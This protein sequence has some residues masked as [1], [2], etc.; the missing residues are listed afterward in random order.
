M[1][2]PTS[3]AHARAATGGGAANP[4][5]KPAAEVHDLLNYRLIERMGQEELATIYRA[6]HL[7]L[8]RPVEV[9]IL[10]RTDWISSSRFQLA[11]KL[12]ARLSHPNILPVV[13][14][15]HDER[16]GAYMVTPRLDTRSLDA[17]LKDGPLDALTALK[18]FTQIGT[19]LDYLHSQ[20]VVHR[21]VQP[22][23]I[24]L[25]PQ[26]SAYLT[27][28]SLAAAP[29]TPD[30]SSIEEA[31]Y[32]TPYSA[33]EQ[34]LISG[35]HAPAHDL[36]SLGAVLY[37][38]L[39]GEEPPPP[40]GEPRPLSTRDATLADADRVIKRLLAAQPA[41]RY[42]GAA[43]AVAALRQAL[44]QQI[45]QSTGDMEE[46]RWEPVAEWLENP[47]ETVVGKLLDHEFVA[48]SR[49]RADGLHRAGVIRKTLDQWSQAG[50]LRRP[51][52]GQVIQ[53]G[54]I[55][56]YDVYLYELRA[57]Y[58]RRTPPQ[59]RQVVPEEG[60]ITP[61]AREIDLWEVPVPEL[62]PFTD[63]GPEPIVI[64]STRRL[65]PCGDCGGAANVTCKSCRGAGQIERVRKV[66]EPDGATRNEPFSE[67][68]PICRGYGKQACPRCEGAGQLLEE[69][70][71]SWS[72]HGKV[73]FNEDDLTG[74]HKLTIQ[75]QAQAVLSSQIDPYQ[76]NW[77]QVEPLKELL[78]QAING[79][80]PDARLITA[81][82][83]IKGVPITE[84]DYT[85][86]G[87]PHSL[88]MI[89]FTNEI[90]GDSVLFDRERATLYVGLVLMGLIA[91]V[92]FLLR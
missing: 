34:S 72:R 37:H 62:A 86:K 45:D 47:L 22:A 90:R 57:H 54:Q 64:A 73:Y 33:P 65:L 48:R 20:G 79:G 83:T 52:L 46:S 89:G 14:A 7:T 10:R 19:A 32:L 66:K 80:G 23:N 75:A 69:Q 18:V 38:M 16:Y 44:R 42:A 91:L 3:N 39:L 12:A 88:T 27:N 6:T 92:L 8:D 84:I 26:G 13:D 49:A 40:G 9:H 17:A 36:Y 63:A 24:L 29:D 4:A 61:A 28:F 51:L 82:L 53:P 5:R 55:V 43:Q 31:D 85:Y 15:G 70:F 74:L 58:E 77:Y 78:E 67:Q 35:E 41:Q 25:T 56:S 30:L 76:S 2:T 11:A 68:C 87:K 71:F 59:T 50:F 60:A 21:D 1:P 81:E